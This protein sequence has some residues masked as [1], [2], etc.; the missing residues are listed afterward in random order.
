MYNIKRVKT[1][2]S[3]LKIGRVKGWS[4]GIQLKFSFYSKTDHYIYKMIYVSLM[5]MTM[6]K[7]TVDTQKIKNIQHILLWKTINSQRMEAT[8][9]EKKGTTKQPKNN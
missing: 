6:Q 2:T 4:F 8:E 3:K 5:I 9:G 7:P 1:V